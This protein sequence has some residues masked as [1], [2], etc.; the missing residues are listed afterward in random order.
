M[1]LD[2]HEIRLLSPRGLWALAPV[3]A[4]IGVLLIVLQSGGGQHRLLYMHMLERQRASLR[5]KVA[6]N[7][8]MRI[9]AWVMQC[10]ARIAWVRGIIGEAAIRQWRKNRLADYALRK[11]FGDWKRKFPDGFKTDGFKN[12]QK[13]NQMRKSSFERTARPY[14]WKPFAL[15]KIINVYG[16]LYGRPALTSG[17]TNAP[18]WTQ[19]RGARLLKPVRF[20]PPELDSELDIEAAPGNAQTIP[21]N[22]AQHLPPERARPLACIGGPTGP[23]LTTKPP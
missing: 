4:L 10:P 18:N 14:I 13:K 3:R 2:M 21:Q 1:E 15:V 23:P 22:A 6:E 7:L 19:P 17:T 5:E 16:F 9:K 11:Y 12:R 20:T 8:N